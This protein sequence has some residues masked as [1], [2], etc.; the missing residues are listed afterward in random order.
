[1][2]QHEVLAAR[3]AGS[4]VI[5]T[6]HTNTERPYLSKVLQ[7]WLQSELNHEDEDGPHSKWEVLVSREDADPLRVV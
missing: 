4:A 3:A 7:S 5:L 6:N 2:K 1:M